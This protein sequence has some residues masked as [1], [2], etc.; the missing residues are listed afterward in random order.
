MNYLAH[1]YLSHHDEHLILG[2]FIADEVKGKKYLDFPKKIQEGILLH[3]L[4]DDFTDNHALVLNSTKTVRPSQRKY[5][6]VVID[7]FYDHLLAKNWKNHA[8]DELMDFTKKVYEILNKHRSIL[9]E[10]SAMRLDYMEK[11]NWLYHYQSQE[12]INHALNGL[13]RRTT[14]ENNM[15]NATKL[16]EDHELSIQFDFEGFLPEIRDY[17]K[18][19]LKKGITRQ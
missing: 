14:F 6:P 11:Q 13:S 10:I 16:L 9:P 3:R 15:N 8:K 7:L 1:F 5:A 12:G 2:N 18:K 4:I 19:H 17:V